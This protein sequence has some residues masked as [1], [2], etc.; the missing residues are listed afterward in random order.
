MSTFRL[1]SEDDP[2]ARKTASIA[3]RIRFSEKPEPAP[4]S[5]SGT[6][7]RTGG[8]VYIGGSV[9]TGG[10]DFVGRDQ[11]KTLYQT[12]EGASAADLVRLLAEVRALLPQAGLDPASAQAIEGDFRIVEEQAAK[13]EPKG[14][15]IKSR[16]KS[17]MELI[18]GAG[19]SSD[20]LEKVVTLVG[21]AAAMAAAIF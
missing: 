3:G 5:G 4:K 13:T 19:E 16:I 12:Q 8:G 2:N 7:V 1:P 20:A 18:Q 10:G 15:L 11:F 17:A 9:T 14:G 6:V 21:R